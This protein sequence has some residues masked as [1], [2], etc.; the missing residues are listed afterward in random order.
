MDAGEMTA[1]VISSKIESPI[2]DVLVELTMLEIMGHITALPG[3]TYK[4][5]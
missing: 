5:S 4:L 1:D 3:G 2:T